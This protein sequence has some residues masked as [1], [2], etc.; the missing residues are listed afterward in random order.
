[1]LLSK[2]STVVTFAYF[3]VVVAGSVLLQFNMEQ[4]KGFGWA[5]EEEELRQLQQCADAN[6]TECV[7][8]VEA[9][10]F[11]ILFAWYFL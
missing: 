7:T 2:Y 1:M 10:L 6:V 3:C 5:K 8:N 4:L 11:D 9:S